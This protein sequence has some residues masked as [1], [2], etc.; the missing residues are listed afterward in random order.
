MKVY[1]IELFLG[2]GKFEKRVIEKKTV[3]GCALCQII[4]GHSCNKSDMHAGK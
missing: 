4:K 2:R 1:L 3:Y